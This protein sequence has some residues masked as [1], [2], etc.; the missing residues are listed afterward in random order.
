MKTEIY[1]LAIIG[2][3]ASGLSCAIAA[4]H[5][6]S[7]F[8]ILLLENK[9]RVGKK[10]LAT[11]NGKC[12]LSNTDKNVEKN[13]HSND[14]NFVKNV[15]D[16]YSADDNVL[17]FNK[18]GLICRSDNEGRIYPYSQHSS[19]V[20]DALRNECDRLDINTKCSV[21][22][23][24]VKKEQE[25]FKIITDNEIIICD[26]LVVSSGGMSY[27]NSQKLSGYDILKKF[28]HTITDL[29]PSLVALKVK[30]P[31][32]SLKGIRIPAVATLY[33]NSQQAQTESGEIQFTEQG[34]SG[35][36]IMQLSQRI[37]R[38]I[39]YRKK[40]SYTVSLDLMPTYTEE[41]I[42]KIIKEKIE[43]NAETPTYELLCGIFHKMLA[44]AIIVA[45]LKMNIP[46]KIA[47]LNSKNI[48]AIVNCIKSFKFDIVGTMGFANAQ[49]TGGGAQLNQF[50]PETMESNL[51]KGLYAAGEVLDVVGACG[52]FNLNWAW[53]SGRIAGESAVKRSKKDA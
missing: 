47:S 4:A 34:I 12:N 16:A 52:G 43:L 27:V 50:N 36:A 23:N 2:A 41:S 8:K 40:E 19:S 22:I 3:G 31:V 38:G 15:F 46:E 18:L 6:S 33:V 32:K 14:I 44:R 13:Y 37:A 5:K 21:T 45:A 25:K 11:G 20:L 42:I 53:S 51:T 24:D 28:G 49:V 7:N 35:I 30:N 9:D 48:E 17:F 26:N 10:I 29:Y 1:D 39:A